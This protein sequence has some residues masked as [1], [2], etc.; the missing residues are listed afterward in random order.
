MD[1]TAH[2]ATPKTSTSHSIGTKINPKGL[3]SEKC[4]IRYDG[5]FTEEVIA[6]LLS[7]IEDSCEEQREQNHFKKKLI[8][9][10]LEIA[11]N[12]YHHACRDEV[13]LLSK[14]SLKIY[15]N[16]FAYLIESSNVISIESKRIL[17]QEFS[18]LKPLSEDEIRM[19]YREQLIRG[20]VVQS[21]AGL[22]LIE[23]AKK[24]GKSVEYRFSEIEPDLFW[25]TL[26]TQIDR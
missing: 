13:G 7:A 12:I 19:R 1:H 15:R 8:K 24:T 3:V 23:I 10:F 22:G 17:Q 2:G 14:S 16:Q 20:E 18:S 5:Q 11:H 4:I 9:I 6:T 26:L 25:F 21:R